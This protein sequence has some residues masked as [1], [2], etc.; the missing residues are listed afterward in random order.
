MPVEKHPQRMFF[1][2]KTR[3]SDVHLFPSTRFRSVSGNID[4]RLKIHQKK[5]RAR[6][7]LSGCPPSGWRFWPRRWLSRQGTLSLFDL[8]AQKPLCPRRTATDGSE[9]RE[10]E[11][12]SLWRTGRCAKGRCAVAD[13]RHQPVFGDENR[14]KSLIF[15]CFYFEHRMIFV[16]IKRC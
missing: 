5:G 3:N 10:R 8:D 13:S 11:G 15:R 1:S 7:P 12:G 4:R 16:T 6:P 9:K 14:L 2:Y